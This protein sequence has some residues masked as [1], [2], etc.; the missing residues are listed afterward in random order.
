VN[1]CFTFTILLKNSLDMKSVPRDLL[2]ELVFYL[3]ISL[4][5]SLDMKS[6]P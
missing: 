6:L 1:W 5:N 3:H 4:K 2:C